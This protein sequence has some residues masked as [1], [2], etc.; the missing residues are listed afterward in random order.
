MPTSSTI[1]I[2]G[3][4]GFVGRHLIQELQRYQPDVRL[5]V[6]DQTLAGLPAG[7]T[8]EMI[9]ITQPRSYQVSLAQHRPDWVIHL[10][11]VSAV[12]ESLRDPGR[13]RQINFEASCALLAT[14]AEES[15]PSKL[16]VVSTA[17]IY[18]QG[19][20]TPLP[21]LPLAQAHPR[22]PYGQTKWEMEQHVEQHYLDRVIRVRPFPHIGP[23][24]RPGFVT[25][26]F[27]SQIAAIEAGQQEPVMAVGNLT[28]Q[29]D[30]TDV[31]D[32][33]RAYR[34]LL[35]HG[36]MGEVYHVASGQ[37][38][39]IKTILDE[40]LELTTATITVAQDQERLRPVDVPILVGDAS[41]LKAVT[42][43]QPA[44]PLQQSLHD[45]LEW[46]RHTPPSYKSRGTSATR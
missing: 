45:I 36:V 30:F 1:L 20:A 19:A 46:W 8:G 24:Q 39:S 26:D 23:G 18:G 9:D 16:L 21:E 29:R 34:L 37:A 12:G 10:A 5:V 44:I 17:D 22:N 40:F 25:A 35:R 38:V 4:A 28:A 33:V 15:P 41:K 42:H 7:V 3:G 32:V 11:A 27:A 13:A 43:W 31:R 2:T 14:V 6:W